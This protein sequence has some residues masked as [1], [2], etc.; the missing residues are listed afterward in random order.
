MKR[1]KAVRSDVPAVSAGIQ[2]RG[3]ILGIAH[4]AQLC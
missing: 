1:T 4:T 3:V 2:P